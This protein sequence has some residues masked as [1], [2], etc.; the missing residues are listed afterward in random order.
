M[1]RRRY[2]L[3][4]AGYFFLISAALGLAA[5][6]T[7]RVD[8]FFHF[9]KP[10]T[11]EYFYVLDNQRSQ[12]NGIERHFDYTGL[13]TGTSMAENFKT[14]D[15]EKLW[16]ASFIK[17]AFS[18]GSYKEINDNV[19]AALRYNPKL[20]IVI[21]GLDMGKF[22]EDKDTMRSDLGT[23]P[24]YLYDDDIFNDV[25][26]IFNRD[27]IFNRVY[28]TPKANADLG[29][30]PGITSFDQY[31]NWMHKYDFGK[32][33]LFPKGITAEAAGEP[34]HFS[35]EDAE[36]VRGQLEQNVTPLAE[37]YPD[38]S[39]YYFFTPYSA[40]WWMDQRTSG[41]IYRQV[42]A[43][44]M[45]IEELLKYPNIRLF[46]FNCRFDLTT[47]LNH[48]KDSL[49][50]AEWINSFMLRCMHDDR[51]RLTSENYRAYLDEELQFYTSYDYTQMNE[52]PDYDDD[53]DPE[54]LAAWEAYGPEGREADPAEED[55]ETQ[56]S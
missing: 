26:Y 24:T 2:I 44:R 28:R 7:V 23:Y 15:A 39:F 20:K 32:N 19:E 3:W 6:K 45:I 29:I 10:Y 27:V 46:S 52:Q 38:V 41:Q 40:Q 21:R 35:E 49:H 34:V 56:T 16:G 55:A 5:F 53:Y 11:N 14:S 4:L 42:E 22:I 8:P 12:N 25:Q 33:A 31:S 18:G 48:Y 43:E 37:Q 30:A 9:H 17:V 1:M 47:N 36:T 13:I 50:Y 54:L 51:Y